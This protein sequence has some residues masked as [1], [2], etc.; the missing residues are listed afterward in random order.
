MDS[1]AP[2]VVDTVAEAARC[3]HAPLIVLEV[4]RDFLDDHGLGSGPVRVS[5]IG[6]GG[7]SNFSFLVERGDG[8]YVLRRPPRPLLPPTAHD[9]VREA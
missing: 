2:E 6:E 8:R 4:L 5:R 7:G 3:E 1:S 9:V